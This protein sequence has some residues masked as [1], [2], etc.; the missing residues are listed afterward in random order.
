MTPRSGSAPTRC[1]PTL[2]CSRRRVPHSR[3]T[4]SSTSPHP[5]TERGLRRG[6][7]EQADLDRLADVVARDTAPAALLDQVDVVWTMT[8]L[9][10]FEA[11]LRGLEVHCLG[12]PS[13]PAGADHRSRTAPPTAHRAPGPGDAG[14]C[15]ADRLSALFRRR[16]RHGLPGRGD[17]GPADKPRP[18]GQPPHLARSQGACR[19]SVPFQASRAHVARLSQRSAMSPPGAGSRPGRTPVLP[20][21]RSAQ[22]PRCPE[23]HRRRSPC[24]RRW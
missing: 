6:L 7:I 18:V 13:M 23:Y 8:S 14:P 12:T 9:M 22:V 2:P 16:D 1:A 17:P 11:L 4:R 10:G 20:P 3:P 24:P 21:V 15:H 5:D 19:A